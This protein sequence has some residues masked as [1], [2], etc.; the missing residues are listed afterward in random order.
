MTFRLIGFLLGILLAMPPR[1]MA[2]DG[3]ALPHFTVRDAEAAIQ[4]AMAGLPT[5]HCGKD[6]CA[7]ATPEEFAEP[8]VDADDAR[9]ALITGARSARLR[10]CGLEWKERAFPL[11]MQGFQQKGIHNIRALAILQ[12]IHTGQFARDYGNLQVLKT[13]SPETKLALDKANPRV[14]L[15]PWQGTVNNALLDESVAGMLQRILGEIHKS[16]CGPELCA[17]ATDEEKAKPPVSI[18]EARRAMK[19]GLL[20]GTAEFCGI[21]WKARIFYPFMAYHDRTLKMSD[22]QLAIVSMLHGTMHSFIVDGYKKRGAPCTDQMRES[23]E[24][25]LSNG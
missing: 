14:E 8:P 9:V 11:M 13:C 12:L 18:E 22:R 5:M 4:Q 24:K 20:S 19:V 17:S 23:L 15:P 10:W 3:E 25:Q 6:P 7:A 1:A 2:E 21:D 16:R